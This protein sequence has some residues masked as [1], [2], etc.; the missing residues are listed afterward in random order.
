MIMDI[1]TDAYGKKVQAISAKE[2]NQFCQ[3]ASTTQPYLRFEES[4]FCKLVDIITSMIRSG[5]DNQSAKDKLL[6]YKEKYYPFGFKEN[7][8]R[9][10]MIDCRRFLYP[11]IKPN[12]EHYTLIEMDVFVMVYRACKQYIYSGLTNKSAEELLSKVYVYRKILS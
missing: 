1:V 10:Y 9:P 2:Y 12:Y 11:R 8:N 3:I 7:M 5:S 4:A 6:K